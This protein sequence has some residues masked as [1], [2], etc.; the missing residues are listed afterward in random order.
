M[1]GLFGFFGQHPDMDRLAMAAVLAARRGPDGWGV[2]TD[3]SYERGLGRLP[4]TLARGIVA[5]RFVVGH[6]RLATVLG[7]KTVQDGQ[8]IRVGRYVVAHNGTVANADH[9]QQTFG[10]QP[11]TRND[12]EA[13]ALLM[14]RMRGTTDE[15]LSDVLNL[16]DH[17]GHYAVTV[18][19]LELMSI[20]LRASRMPL[21]VHRAPEGVYWCS[22]RP[23]DT[24]EG[25]RG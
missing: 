22:I 8:P 9:L 3:Y 23:D 10:Y 1:C 6:C 11:S 15:R 2:L 16:I 17:G 5:E 24:W 14:H 20:H 25:C 19:D 4:A 21:W 12:S 18:L 13:I 7:S